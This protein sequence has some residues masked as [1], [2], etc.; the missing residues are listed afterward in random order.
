MA[1]GRIIDRPQFNPV[2]A[3]NTVTHGLE[4]GSVQVA[5]SR[6]GCRALN[7]KISPVDRTATQTHNI[8]TASAR[9]SKDLRGSM[10]ASSHGSA[11]R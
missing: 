1:V 7:I 9:Q 11:V 10:A 8:A 5:G 6:L 4:H 2:S 3:T